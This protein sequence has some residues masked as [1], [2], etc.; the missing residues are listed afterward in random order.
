LIIYAGAI[1]GGLAAAGIAWL[2]GGTDNGPR[3]LFGAALG[4]MLGG[5]AV[6]AY[7]TR[8]LDADDAAVTATP[9]VPA[10]F[11]RDARGRWSVGTP[12]PLPVFDGHG[13]R[14]IGATFNALGGQF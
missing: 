12:G 2:I 7:A 9:A 4:G 10:I 11:A 14:V 8:N 5:I 13:T 3:G 1:A 6:A